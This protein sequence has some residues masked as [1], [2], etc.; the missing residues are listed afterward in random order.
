MNSNC[1]GLDKL[2]LQLLLKERLPKAVKTSVHAITE[3]LSTALRGFFTL[4]ISN[5]LHPANQHR[6]LHDGDEEGGVVD[7]E[8]ARVVEGLTD[9]DPVPGV[10]PVDNAR[11]NRGGSG[12]AMAAA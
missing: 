1:I 5:R 7:S 6:L 4:P 2:L 11:G 12:R 10:E 9:H 8:A 3:V